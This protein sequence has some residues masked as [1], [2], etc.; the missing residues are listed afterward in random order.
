M[1]SQYNL[2]PGQA[3]GIRNLIH[4]VAKHLKMQGFIS[5]DENM[6]P[7]YTEE[8]NERVSAVSECLDIWHK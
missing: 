7:K 3:Y 4:V 8:R 2:E 5:R 1:V 6:G